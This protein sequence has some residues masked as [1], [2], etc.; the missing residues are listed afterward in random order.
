MRQQ[1]RNMQVRAVWVATWGVVLSSL[2]VVHVEGEQ[3]AVQPSEMVSQVDDTYN[4]VKPKWNRDGNLLSFEKYGSRERLLFIYDQATRSES[5]I[6][7]SVQKSGGPQTSPGGN[8]MSSQAVANFDMSWSKTQSAHFTFIG[9]G[10]EGNF[11]MYHQSVGGQ[12]DGLELIAGG[13]QGGPYVA[14][15]EYH[16]SEEYLVFCLGQKAASEREEARLDIYA[17]PQTKKG[18]LHKISDPALI[19]LP[20]LEPTVSPTGEMVAFTGVHNGNNDI[21]IAPLKIKE[22]KNNVQSRRPVVWRNAARATKM[23]SPEGRPSWSPDGSQIAFISGDKQRKDE[24]GLWVMNADSSN[25]RKLVDRVL[26]ED[27]PEWHPDSEHIFFVRVLEEDL[28]PIQYVNVKTGKLET[29]ATGTALHTYL[30]ISNKGDKIA[31]CAK[32]R[33]TD[34]DLTWLKLYVAPLQKMTQR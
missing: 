18:E 22:S 24:W 6:K 8:M 26:G 14:Y 20:Q 27:L 5:E 28:N 32:G 7:S 21:Y 30:D 1:Q 33:K 31:F 16:P 4:Y 10:D 25:P 12:P 17:V 11:G 34:K 15:P 9:S 13:E 2:L 23:P 29:L 3:F 19:G